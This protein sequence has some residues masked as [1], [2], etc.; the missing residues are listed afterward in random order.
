MHYRNVLSCSDGHVH[1]DMY[2]FITGMYCL[3]AM[4]FF[5][6]FCWTRLSK[7]LT[8]HLL[9]VP[10]PSLSGSSFR[11]AVEVAFSLMFSSVCLSL[12]F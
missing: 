7:F 11:F 1:I 9:C 5:G 3:A 4:A 8:R 2:T 6:L 12:L 10:S